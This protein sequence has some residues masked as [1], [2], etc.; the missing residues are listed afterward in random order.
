MDLPLVVSRV[1]HR[2]TLVLFSS[3]DR[4]LRGRHQGLDQPFS[5]LKTAS[6]HGDVDGDS[7]SDQLLA[8]ISQDTRAARRTRLAHSLGV[9]VSLLEAR[10]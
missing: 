1:I 5:G 2:R 4:Q 10:D 6:D 9:L 3:G 8:D 7:Y